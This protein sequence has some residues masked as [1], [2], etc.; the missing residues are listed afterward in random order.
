MSFHEV[1]ERSTVAIMSHQI[2]F[3]LY[4]EISQQST[5]LT[6]CSKNWGNALYTATRKARM[7]SFLRYWISTVSSESSSNFFSVGRSTIIRS[8]LDSP[9]PGRLLTYHYYYYS[10]VSDRSG[11][12]WRYRH[13]HF[14]SKLGVRILSI[15]SSFFSRDFSFVLFGLHNRL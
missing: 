10:M 5:F 12:R 2:A 9:T 7:N 8:A 11:T 1:F 6:F 3:G 4:L 14:L 13:R 15:S